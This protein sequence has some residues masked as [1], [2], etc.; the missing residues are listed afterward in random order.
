MKGITGVDKGSSKFSQQEIEEIVELLKNSIFSFEEIA[1][2][3]NC[4]NTTISNINNGKH[5]PNSSYTYPIRKKKKT[6][7]K[8]S[9]ENLNKIYELIQNT[10]MSFAQIAKNFNVSDS[11]IGRINSGKSHFNESKDYPLRKK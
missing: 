1:E 9:K 11:T 6:T 7:S 3:F 4:C 2:K 8:L 5:Y 10:N